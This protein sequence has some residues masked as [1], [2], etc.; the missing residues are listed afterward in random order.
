MELHQHAY[1]PKSLRALERQAARMRAEF[2]RDS[3]RAT[4]RSLAALIRGNRKPADRTA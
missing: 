1:D 2:I 4:W 3:L